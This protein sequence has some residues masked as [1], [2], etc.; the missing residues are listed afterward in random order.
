MIEVLNY[1]RQVFM[2]RGCNNH[3][4]KQLHNSF[5]LVEC[6]STKH[7]KLSSFW[8]AILP[9]ILLIPSPYWILSPYFYG[10]TRIRPAIHN[11]PINSSRHHWYLVDG[12]PS[13][14]HL[15][16]FRSKWHVSSASR[17][18]RRPLEGPE[19]GTT[20]HSHKALLYLKR[21]D[22]TWLASMIFAN[23][24]DSFIKTTST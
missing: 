21:E 5:I 11:Q 9:N 24:S 15:W 13:V 6:L 12:N 14:N 16:L 7:P 2:R 1:L 8:R 19:Y 3:I 23:R 18:G 17:L 4:P 22:I 20:L 10:E